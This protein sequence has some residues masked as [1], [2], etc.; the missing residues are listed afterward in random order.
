MR[1]SSGCGDVRKADLIDYHY[2]DLA[3]PMSSSPHPSLPARG[4]GLEP[5]RLSVTEAASKLGVSRQRFSAIVNCCSGIPHELPIRF[6]KAFGSSADTWYR[7]KSAWEQA[8]A[9]DRSHC[10]AVERLPAA[11]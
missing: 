2:E 5:L 7:L 8:W 9:K 10:I 3:L 1:P 11:T 4:D 6:D